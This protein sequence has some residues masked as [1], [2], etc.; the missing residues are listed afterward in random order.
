[1]R[2]QILAVAFCAAFVTLGAM[3]TDSASVLPRNW[4]LTGNDAQNYS[5]SVEDKTLRLYSVQDGAGFG[6][7]MQT[8]SSQNYLGKNVQ[9]SADVRSAGVAAWTVLWMRVDGEG[10]KVLAFDN[11]QQRPI[12]GSTEWK[13]YSVVLPV[14]A[15]SKDIAFGVL[16]AGSGS[17]WIKNLTFGATDAPSTS[18]SPAA[19]SLPTEPNLD[20]G[21]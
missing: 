20:L 15:S 16:L 7:A 21:P 13:T 11:M 4:M 14:D 8:I 2:R 3:R 9:F 1:M 6:T 18:T 12:K 19:P 10:G 17:V 5:V